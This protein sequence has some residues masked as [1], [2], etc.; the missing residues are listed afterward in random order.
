MQIVIIAGFMIAL[1]TGQM[2]TAT[3]SPRL[4]FLVMVAYL[5]G[6]AALGR[7]DA[8]LYLRAARREGCHCR[9]AIRRHAVASAAA[10][11]WLLGGLA[12][13]MLLGYGRHLGLLAA[14]PLAAKAAAVAPFLLGVVLVW[15]FDYPVHRAMRTGLPSSAPEPPAR[16]VWTAWQYLAYNVRHHL[17]TVAVPVGLIIMFS[18]SLAMLVPRLVG[19]GA[20]DYV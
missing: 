16:P 4:V 13:L 12:G 7:A 20:V 2:P 9:K 3:S 17:L 18:D 5:I 1:A 8:V 10:R 11:V 15:T 14:V 19:P 6:A